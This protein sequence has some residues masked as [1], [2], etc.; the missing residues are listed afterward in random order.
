[1][2]R[3]WYLGFLLILAIGMVVTGCASGEEFMILTAEDC[4]DDET[5]DE[6]TQYCYLTCELDGTCA[7][8]P[9]LLS[10]LGSFISEVGNV[11]LGPPSDASVIITYD[12]EG[13]S[14]NNPVEG[15]SSTAQENGILADTAKHQT[16]WQQFVSL[17]PIENRGDI[18]QYGIFTDGEGQTMA[19][20]EPNSNDP[21]KWNIVM[22]AV[23]AENK[24]EQRYTLIH[25][26][27]HILTLNNRQVPYDTNLTEDDE[28]AYEKAAQSCPRFFTGE[29]CATTNSYVNAFFQKFWTDIY[30]EL[31]TDPEDYEAVGDFYDQ[32]QDRFVTGYAATNPGEDIAES[33][34][35]FVLNDKPSG[36]SIA[37]QKVRFFYDYPELVTLRDQILSRLYSQ[38]RR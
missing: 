7:E 27:G 25:E 22:D 20:V 2:K 34:A 28:A 24:K 15:S 11:A 10:W 9:G 17:I 38:S 31:P 32:Y 16:M 4:F 1:M 6:Q 35:H 8:N 29:G 23:D 26:F 5:Y 30:S 36:D 13:D 19:Y 37:D 18:I 14:I 33:W 21:T 3:I 12:V